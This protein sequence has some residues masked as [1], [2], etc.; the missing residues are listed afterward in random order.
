MHKVQSANTL[1]ASGR[2][3]IFKTGTNSG[4]GKSTVELFANKGWNVAATV[5]NKSAHA[6]LFR[7]FNNVKLYELDVTN[8]EGVNVVAQAAIRDFN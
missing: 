3:A 5:R 6:D 2:Q 4:F 1:T 8:F 7:N